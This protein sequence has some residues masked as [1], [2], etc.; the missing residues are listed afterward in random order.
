MSNSLGNHISHT[1]N[2]TPFLETPNQ[3]WTRYFTISHFPP[4]F[5]PL[6]PPPQY[7]PSSGVEGSTHPEDTPITYEQ[8]KD[9]MNQYKA[10]VEEMRRYN[11]MRSSQPQLTALEQPPQ[12]PNLNTVQS[13]SFETEDVSTHLW[14]YEYSYTDRSDETSEPSSTWSRRKKPKTS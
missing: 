13:N 8:Y 12:R 9:L 10:M 6:P 7:T 14:R 1:Q 3:T 11:N 5:T 4:N 2:Q